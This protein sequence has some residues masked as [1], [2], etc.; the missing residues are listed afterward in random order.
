MRYVQFKRKMIWLLRNSVVGFSESHNDS[1]I[2]LGFTYGLLRTVKLL[3]AGTRRTYEPFSHSFNRQ[4]SH[5]LIYR[6][7]TCINM[8]IF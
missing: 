6:S 8:F 7:Y 5:G 2:A 3:S 4:A 1:A